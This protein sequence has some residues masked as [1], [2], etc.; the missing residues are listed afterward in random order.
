MSTSTLPYHKVRANMD[1]LTE[2]LTFYGFAAGSRRAGFLM[3]HD[4]GSR[5]VLHVHTHG[6][7][8]ARRDILV[9]VAVVAESVGQRLLVLPQ[10]AAAP[11]DLCVALL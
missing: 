1:A 8:Y 5:P 11:H 2:V 4:S 3:H 10:S 6:S 7:G 9:L